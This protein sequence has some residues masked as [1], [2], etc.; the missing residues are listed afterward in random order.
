MLTPLDEQA[1]IKVVQAGNKA[2]FNAIV[3]TYQRPIFNLCYRM[4]N[5]S[6]AA[7]DAAQEVFLRA[8]LKLD[9]Y[10][11]SRKFS[12]WLFAIASHH[13]LDRLRKHR[14]N[15]VSLAVLPDWQVPAD[16]A[17]RLEQQ[18][19]QADQEAEI[20]QLLSGL[21]AKQRLIVIMHYWHRMSIV[22]IGEAMK[23]SGGAI[24]SRLFRARKQMAQMMKAEE[25]GVAHK[26]SGATGLAQNFT[27]GL[28][29]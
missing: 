1:C 2:A 18:L 27:A 26:R 10:D 19:I 12:T 9:S 5:D 14:L 7:E 15:L 6:A 22:E 3:E 21:S 28:P 17:P 24:K 16:N 25:N 23:M 8:Y 11:Q 4:L 29:G 13:C 20:Q